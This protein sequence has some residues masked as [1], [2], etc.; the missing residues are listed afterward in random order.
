LRLSGVELLLSTVAFTIAAIVF[1]AKYEIPGLTE[2]NLGESTGNA[3][4]QAPVAVDVQKVTR[5]F[6]GINSGEGGWLVQEEQGTLALDAVSFGVQSGHCV[7]LLGPNGAGKTTLVRIITGVDSPSSGSVAVSMALCC[8]SIGVCMQEN[9][10]FE[11]LTV[12][13]HVLLFSRVKGRAQSS[14][15][16]LELLEAVGLAAKAHHLPEHLSGGMQRKLA[17]CCA[18]LGSP[19]VSVLDEPTVSID[20]STARQPLDSL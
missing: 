6:R 4:E 5:A 19:T 20:I 13:E 12:Y 7:G 15:Q 1:D 18:L 2:G 8:G 11:D 14:A 17:I 9:V 10:H 3:D 16:L